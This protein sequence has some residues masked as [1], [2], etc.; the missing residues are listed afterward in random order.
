MGRPPA[1][2]AGLDRPRPPRRDP[3]PAPGD[4][5]PGCVLPRWLVHRRTGVG[6][7]AGRVLR[8]GSWNNNARNTR[9]SNRNRNTPDNRNERLGL[10][11]A[12]SARVAF[13]AAARNPRGWRRGG[14]GARVSMS[15]LPVRSGR[16][17]RIVLPGRRG[18]AQV[19][20]CERGAP[21][22]LTGL[23]VMTSGRTGGR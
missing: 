14:R 7:T 11:L 6:P 23:A 12:Q 16:N 5:R 13:S 3:G 17:G 22:F 8:G 19:A 15:R 1:G 9:V 18:V 2:G 20:S 10:R 4:L 21:I